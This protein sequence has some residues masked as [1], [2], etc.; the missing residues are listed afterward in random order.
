MNEDAQRRRQNAE[1]MTMTDY[2][3]LTALYVNT[4]LKREPSESHTRLLLD[5]S[6]AIMRKQGVAVDEVHLLEH[7]VPPG[8]YP[9]MTEHGWDRDDWPAIWERVL[10]ADILVVGTPLWLG[11]ES[12]VVGVARRYR[13]LAATLVIDEVDRELADAVV[14]AGMQP[15]VMPTIM[16]EP[17]VAAA[18]ARA[19]H[20]A[21][22][23]VT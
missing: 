5:A 6:A 3:H 22:G 15:I 8:V 17:G 21:A 10:A 9:D 13:D 20:D 7:Q 19:C 4:S 11:E 14:D 1:G 16:S 18:L 2:Q 23:G 12:S